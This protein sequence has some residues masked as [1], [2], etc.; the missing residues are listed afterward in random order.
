M[1]QV[2][3][4]F[5]RVL[6]ELLREKVIIFWTIVFP[7]IWL[8]MAKIIFLNG[9]PTEMKASLMGVFTVSMSIYALM[10]A[11]IVDL[12]G[13]IA[14]DRVKG[15]LTKLKSMPISP[16]RD[17]TGRVSA[18]SAFSVIA[19]AVLAVVGTLLG[20][21]FEVNLSGLMQS[22]GFILLGF[23]AAAGMGLIIGTLIKREQSATITGIG[24]TIVGG[25]MSGLFTTYGNLPDYLQAFSR[26]FPPSSCN[27]SIVYSLFGAQWAGY[28][29]LETGQLAMTIA[30]SLALF[31]I[32]LLLY[33]KQCW[34]SE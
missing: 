12:P 15:T 17:F 19:I 16:W 8:V 9:A 24:I 20:A 30:S 14:N 28:N 2:G 22:I 25:F 1:S 10:I 34:R 26:L 27:S 21:K 23:A 6:K 3:A 31:A 5:N 13:N 32:G 4:T 7:V 18:F 33:S 11:G 29:P